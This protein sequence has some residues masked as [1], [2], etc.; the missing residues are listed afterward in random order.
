MMKPWKYSSVLSV[1]FVTI[2]MIGLL[3]SEP[4]TYAQVQ[5]QESECSSVYEEF[6]MLEP[7]LVETEDFYVY[8][9]SFGNYSFRKEMPYLMNFRCRDKTQLIEAGMFWVNTSESLVPL[10]PE[11]LVVNNTVFQVTV[12]V[13][14]L[15]EVMGHLTVTVYFSKDTPPKFEVYLEKSELWDLGNFNIVWALITNGKYCKIAEHE[16]RYFGEHRSLELVSTKFLEVEVGPEEDYGEWRIWSLTL[17]EDVGYGQLYVGKIEVAEVISAT[18]I[19]IV[20]EENLD[21]IDPITVAKS[22]AVTAVGYTHQVKNFYALGRHWVFFSNGTDLMFS[23]STDGSTWDTPTFV[24]AG[25][26]RG[27]MFSIYWD[28]TYVNVAIGT[29]TPS[30]PLIYKRGVAYANGTIT[31]DPEVNAVSASRSAAYYKVTIVK[32]SNGYPWIGYQKEDRIK[33]EFYPY[34][35]RATSTDGT[36]WDPTPDQ[37]SSV[38]GHWAVIPVPLTLGKVLALY[39][40]DGTVIYGKEWDGGAWGPQFTVSASALLTEYHWKAV[41][42][43]ATDDVFITFCE[44]VNYDVIF[45][46]RVGGVWS[47]ELTLHTAIGGDYPS[48]SITIHDSSGELYVLY[49]DNEVLYMRK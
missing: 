15:L 21:L 32:D 37:L 10:N 24:K 34:V 12:E 33:Y 46:K 7:F 17:W 3:R 14:R 38:D 41:S 48:P 11:V 30:E 44:E 42:R 35:V 2:L 25:I 19:L 23:S 22:T 9:T 47:S 49:F 4:V 27:I 45:I 28:G 31:W 40:A 20:F 6:S 43:N 16:T 8:V 5:E 1:V 13:A 18:G 39:V 36:T 29:A 26:T